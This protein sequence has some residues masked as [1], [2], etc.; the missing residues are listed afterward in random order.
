MCVLCRG[1]MVV[2]LEIKRKGHVR[3]AGF[4]TWGADEKIIRFFNDEE[5]EEEVGLSS[6]WGEGGIHVTTNTKDNR[7][8]TR[9]RLGC[10]TSILFAVGKKKVFLFLYFFHLPISIGCSYTKRSLKSSGRKTTTIP[11]FF[12]FPRSVLLAFQDTFRWITYSSQ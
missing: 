10:Q 8:D 11:C 1:A 5:E 3:G 7:W 9:G 6:V 2:I 12:S 4:G